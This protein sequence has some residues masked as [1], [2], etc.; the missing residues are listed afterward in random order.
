[1]RIIKYLPCLLILVL[2]PYIALSGIHFIRSDASGTNDG[3]DWANAWTDLPSSFIRGDTYYVADGIYGGH[4]FNTAESGSQ[5]IYVKKAIELDHGTSI[6]WQFS[7]GDGRAQFGS[8][9]FETGYWD[10]DGQVGGGP[11]S[12]DSGHGFYIPLTGGSLRCISFET[13]APE[14]IKI[15][16]TEMEGSGFNLGDGVRGDGIYDNGLSVHSGNYVGYCYFHDFNRTALL[17][18]RAKQGIIEYN[19][20]Y[21][22]GNLAGNPHSEAMSINYG[23]TS[24]DT[25]IRYNYI[26]TIYGTG[27][28]VIKAS[29]Q[30]DYK[31]YGNLFVQESAGVGNGIVVN[32]SGDT[33]TDMLVYNN[34]FVRKE[35][36]NT[37]GSIVSWY[38][39]DAT[40]KAYNNI[41][42]NLSRTN[43]WGTG[44]D[45]NLYDGTVN[46]ESNGQNW[47]GGTSLFTDY[48]NNDFTLSQATNNGKDDLGSPYD[49]DMY[50]NTRG[51]DGVWDIGA[52]EWPEG[53]H[54]I[55]SPKN[56]RLK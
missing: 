5:Y 52:F 21:R 11:G 8:L 41:Y 4:R 56:L 51:L 24:A 54:R 6:G 15:R 9:I 14:H 48:S 43:I 22:I 3:N 18:Y 17:W 50:E 45:Y 13:H 44:H 12:W 20:M 26:K 19:Y 42:Y 47:T 25:Y 1:M 23:T 34:T 36:G 29:V 30:G 28:I 49:Q 40:N 27:F 31:I 32:T 37:G 33:N 55:N 10:F 39:G 38:N 7:Y 46:G 16:H 53:G 35:G 2:I